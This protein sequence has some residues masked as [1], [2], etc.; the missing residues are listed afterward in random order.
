MSGATTRTSAGP[1][2]GSRTSRR[3]R[4]GSRSR[5]AS[6]GSA[7]ANRLSAR[8]QPLRLLLVGP[9]RA[10]ESLAAALA[11]RGVRRVATLARGFHGPPPEWDLAIFA[12]PDAEIENAAGAVAAADVFI[13]RPR[14]R[15][16]AL[17]LAGSLDASALACLRRRGIAVGSFHPAVAFP[18]RRTPSAVLRGATFAIEGDAAAVRL[19]AGL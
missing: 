4:P 17:H 14:H 3:R 2:S 7:G 10:G 16:V 18:S 8:R 1:R 19:A 15:R 11:L 5:S 6:L 13:P 12:V 9:G